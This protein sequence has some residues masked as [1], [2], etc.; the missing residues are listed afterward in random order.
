MA[1]VRRNLDFGTDISCTDDINPNFAIVEG[2]IA[3]AQAA[4]RRLSTPRGR[5]YRYPNYG[6]DLRHR[7]S[8][9]EDLDTTARNIEDELLKDE[10]ISDVVASV[11]FVDDDETAL[12]TGKPIGTMLIGVTMF[13]SSGPFSLVLSVDDV[14]VDILELS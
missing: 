2:N 5:L 12:S 6:Y 11:T 9:E 13:A 7:I 1:Q 8:V 4:Q 3:L 14:S 10:R